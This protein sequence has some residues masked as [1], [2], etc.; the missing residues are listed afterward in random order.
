MSRIV[1]FGL[2]IRIAGLLVLVTRA[3]GLAA[4]AVGP[5]GLIGATVESFEGMRPG[6]NIVAPGGVYMRMIGPITFNSGVMLTGPFPQ[7]NVNRAIVICDFSFHPGAAFSL[8]D[9]GLIDSPADVPDGSAFLAIDDQDE[10]RPFEFTFPQTVQRVGALVTG[11]PRLSAPSPITMTAYD[12][13]GTLLDSSTILSAPVPAWSSNFLGIEAAG[14]HKVTIGGYVI[15]VDALSFVA[16]PEPGGLLLA[17][18]ISGIL[19][20]VGRRRR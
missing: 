7:P 10:I 9:Y 6:G 4:A 8:G 20:L 15:V 13:N 5:E 11:P 16:V 1:R 17:G 2:L 3:P 12:A 14:I 19:V 18:S